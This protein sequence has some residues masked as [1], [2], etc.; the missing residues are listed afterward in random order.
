MGLRPHVGTIHVVLTELMPPTVLG[1]V[2]QSWGLFPQGLHRKAAATPTTT[3]PP[4]GPQ[5][6]NRVEYDECV[7]RRKFRLLWQHVGGTWKWGLVKESSLEDLV[8][9]L[10]LEANSPK[11]VKPEGEN[12]GYQKQV[13][14]VQCCWN[15][16]WRLEGLDL[17]GPDATA[18]AW[19]KD[20]KGW[21]CR[22]AR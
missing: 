13:P 3:C 18:W 19:W 12:S 1:L 10:G 5:V 15:K 2:I 11:P 21:S 7:G 14:V 17:E 22:K 4:R 20:M 8:P 9:K 16:A 6:M